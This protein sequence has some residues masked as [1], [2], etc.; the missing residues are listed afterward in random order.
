MEIE[1]EGLSW[2]LKEQKNFDRQK[3][4]VALKTGEK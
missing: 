3:W 4:G 2:V 1:K